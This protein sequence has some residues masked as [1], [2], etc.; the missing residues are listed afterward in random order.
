VADHWDIKVSVTP[1]EELTNE[2]S[3]TEK[4]IASEVGK[5]LAGSGTSVDLAN[6]SGSAANQGYTGGT[7]NYF[8]TVV[9]DGTVPTDITATD[10]YDVIF[11]RNTGYKY[12]SATALGSATTDCVMVA[13]E[14]QAWS[15]GALGG[16]ANASDTGVLHYYEVAWLKPGQAIV[17]PLGASKN[18]ITKIGGNAGDLSPLDKQADSAGHAHVVLKTFQSDGSEATDG[19]AIEFLCCT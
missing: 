3:G 5:S 7:V 19:N 11:I 16:Y 15:T 6:Y 13:I 1:I 12:S 4:I 10:N 2:N 9:G 18:T 8:D 14:E 17:L